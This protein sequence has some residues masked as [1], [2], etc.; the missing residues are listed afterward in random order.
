MTLKS[1][2]PATMVAVC[3]L[4]ATTAQAQN[5]EWAAAVSGDWDLPANWTP[6]GPPLV[7]TQS[8]TIGFTDPFTVRIDVVDP[9]IDDLSITNASALVDL[10]QNTTLAVAGLNNEGTIR[11]NIDNSALDSVLSFPAPLAITG[12]GEIQLLAGS[13]NSR[14]ESDFAVTNGASHLIRG[15]G[16]SRVPW[17]NLGEIRADQGVALS[18]TDLLLTQ[19]DITNDGTLSAVASSTLSV[20][21]ITIDQSGGGELRVY[22]PLPVEKDTEPTP[23]P[24][25][26]EKKEEPER[27]TRFPSS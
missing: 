14:L 3:G 12:G 15:V 1:V 5:F 7:P 13:N 23:T 16:E 24:K 26:K 19:D 18:G 11:L 4:A 8:A 25:P 22:E 10:R 2:C 27:K 6:L 9:N 21:G 20:N 17:T